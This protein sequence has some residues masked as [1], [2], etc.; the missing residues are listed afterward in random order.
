M[1]TWNWFWIA[2]KVGKTDSASFFELGMYFWNKL[3]EFGIRESPLE[4]LDLFRISFN[5]DGNKEARLAMTHALLYRFLYNDGDEF[6]SECK[7]LLEKTS[8]VMTCPI[9]CDY[10]LTFVKIIMEAD[11][12]GHRLV[13]DAT[14]G[15][16]KKAAQRTPTLEQFLKDICYEQ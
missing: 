10:S 2:E 11:R 12:F 4:A 8:G 1:K 13:N 16:L 5:I 15:Q 14:F 6:L 7:D 3:N 9:E